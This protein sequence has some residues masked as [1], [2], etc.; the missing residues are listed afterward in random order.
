MRIK[1]SWKLTSI[2]CVVIF[3]TLSI[4]HFCISILLKTRI[5]PLYVLAPG[6]I[7]AIVIGVVISIMIL[8]PLSE[9]SS[10]AKKMA[11]GD[12]SKKVY[13]TSDD[14]LGDL[15]IS[16]NHMAEEIKYN[17]GKISYEEAKLDAVISS[18]FEGIMLTS[19]KGRILMINPSLKKLFLVDSPPEG[20][21]P[22]E[23]LRNNDIQDMV[24]I[25]IK[26]R[27][28]MTREC[29][30]SNFYE[31]KTVLINGAPVIKE[32]AMQGVI[33]VFHDITEIK[34]LE[35]MRRD[36]VANVSHELR[37]PLSNIKGYAETLLHGALEDKIHAQDF[38]CVIYKE[39]DRLAK[40]IDDLLDLSK[41][42]SGKIEIMP[43]PYSIGAILANAAAI[44]KKSANDKHI[45]IKIAPS[46]D[47]PKV[48][49]DESRLTQVA[50]N[51][52]DNAIKFTPVNGC[53]KIS[54]I[55][56]DGFVQ[57]DISDT[58]PGIPEKDLPRIF[59][60]FYRVDKSHSRDLGGTGLGLSIVKHIVQLHGGEVWVFSAL[61]RGSTFSFTIP[62]A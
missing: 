55:K 14:Q 29:T 53:I 10:T 22:I 35:R 50:L 45:D 44:L 37:T 19:E 47:V 26:Y 25:I 59:E 31:E 23:V 5:S 17:M 49:A 39:S 11:K 15:A 28:N 38:T 13:I 42:E 36:F 52:L 3:C 60:R 12:F 54:F 40:L 51:L 58:G 8:K 41:I 18:M 7:L 57:T 27:R 34:R 16:L 61:G 33:L 24:D 20:K 48:L 62:A 9:I 6:I 43:A 30:L 32:G 21:R 1:L 46:I 56:K 2:F 4:T